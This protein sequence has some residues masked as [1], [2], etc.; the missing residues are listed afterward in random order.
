M[1]NFNERAKEM[2]LGAALG[3]AS[4]VG[5]GILGQ[6]F[7]GQN[8]RRQLKANKEMASFNYELNKRM[9]NETNFNYSRQVEEM[10]K[11]G[12]NPTM[13]FAGGP[14][15]AGGATAPTVQ[16]VSKSDA[17]EHPNGMQGIM[18]GLQAGMM[19]AQI[20]ALRAGANKDNAEAGATQGYK[21]D[22]A[23]AQTNIF[24]QELENLKTDVKNKEALTSL[25]KVQ[26]AYQEL[27]NYKQL[28]TMEDDISFIKWQARNAEKQFEIASNES[29][30]LEKSKY[31]QISSIQ[32]QAATSWLMTVLIKAQTKNVTED[33]GLKVKQG[34]A[35][36]K[37]MQLTDAQIT[38]IGAKIQQKNVELLQGWR[39]LNI[40]QKRQRIEGVKNYVESLYKQH[41]L[42]FGLYAPPLYDMERQYEELMK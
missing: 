19:E 2:G 29:Y 10:K 30:V 14:G 15:G 35:I 41:S 5:S 21:K 25:T 17:G 11:A 12:L 22:S 36:D 27:L 31:A 13:M 40:D 18:A 6:L 24:V 39:Q 20:E 38:E 33:T 26:Q 28:A 1:G 3:M 32:A 9:Y 34:Q 16:G 37:G 42:G 23:E 4:E 8:T 7:A